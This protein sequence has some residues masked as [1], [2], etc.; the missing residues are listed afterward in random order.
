MM[1]HVDGKRT[2]IPFEKFASFLSFGSFWMRSENFTPDTIG[3]LVN[4]RPHAMMGGEIEAYQSESVPVFLYDL[5]I[6][7]PAMFASLS[8]A[9]KD[10]TATP[11]FFLKSKTGKVA[12][13][14]LPAGTTLE[15]D[16]ETIEVLSGGMVKVARRS[17]ISDWCITGRIEVTGAIKPGALVNVTPELSQSLYDSGAFFPNR[18]VVII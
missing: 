14:T 6:A 10:R 3:K 12:L 9:I 18:D 4:L 17:G 7:R 2:G 5:K 13:E 11:D 16:G 8:D 1:N 15:S